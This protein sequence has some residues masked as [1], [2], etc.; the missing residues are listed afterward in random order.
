MP[1]AKP[2]SAQQGG[3]YRSAEAQGPRAHSRRTMAVVEAEGQRPTR[4]TK[5]SLADDAKTEKPGPLAA[6]E[7]GA[8]HGAAMDGR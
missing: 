4:R 8:S 1:T 5:P 3:A 2:Q 7:V 6:V